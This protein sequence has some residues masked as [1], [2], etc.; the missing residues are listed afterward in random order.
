MTFSLVIAVVVEFSFFPKRDKHGSH[1]HRFLCLFC[2]FFLKGVNM[3][4]GD[5]DQ[6]TALHLAAAEGHVEVVRFLLE[7]CKVDPRPKDRYV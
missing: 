5:Y 7:K 3:G 4:Q 6:R 1:F 2:R